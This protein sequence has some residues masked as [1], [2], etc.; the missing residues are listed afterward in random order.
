MELLYTESIANANNFAENCIKKPTHCKVMP[1]ESKIGYFSH[2]KKLHCYKQKYKLQCYTLN[3][4]SFDFME[5]KKK[6]KKQQKI[7]NVDEVVP[8]RL[9][10]GF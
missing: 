3:R 10:Q 8:L 9:V 7:E 6:K 5:K 1:A 4:I 2:P